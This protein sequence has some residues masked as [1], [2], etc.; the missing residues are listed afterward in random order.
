MGTTIAGVSRLQMSD[1]STVD[2]PAVLVDG[3]GIELIVPQRFIASHDTECERSDIY[4]DG[5]CLCDSRGDGP[6]CD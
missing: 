4:G 3:R 1:G 6:D 5:L 2:V